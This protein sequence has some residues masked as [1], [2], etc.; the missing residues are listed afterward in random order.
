MKKGQF[1]LIKMGYK[2]K[3]K[4]FPSKGRVNLCGRLLQ[5]KDLKLEVKSQFLWSN[6]GQLAAGQ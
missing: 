4:T 1:E 3:K 2:K 6:P 5:T